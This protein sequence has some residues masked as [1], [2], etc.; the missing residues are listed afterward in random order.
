MDNN[1]LDIEFWAIVVIGV[2]LWFTLG[3]GLLDGQHVINGG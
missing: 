1:K 3:Y 2:V